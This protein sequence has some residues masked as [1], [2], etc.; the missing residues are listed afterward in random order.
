VK[1]H[2]LESTPRVHEEIYFGPKQPLVERAEWREDCVFL[3]KSASRRVDRDRDRLCGFSDVPAPVWNFK[4]GG[5]QVCDKWLKDRKGT[6][7]T[8]SKITHY[9]HIVAAIKVT[10]RIMSSIDDAIAEHGGWPAA[11]RKV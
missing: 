4:I 3:N 9:E 2:L 6:T 1:A 7:L 11:F 8:A 5:Y 10:L